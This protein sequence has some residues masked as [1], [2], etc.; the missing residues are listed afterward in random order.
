MQDAETLRATRREAILTSPDS[1]LT[2]LGDVDTKKLGY[3]IDEIQ[4]STWVVAQQNGKVVGMAACK[5]PDQGEDEESHQDSRYIESVWIDPDLR[6]Q[7]LGER[8]IG[9]LMAVEFLKNLNVRQF[10]LWVF[11]TNLSAISLYK[12]LGFVRTPGE[13]EGVRTEIKYRLDVNPE[14]HAAIRQ[15]V[16]EVGV[17]ADKENY[18]VTYR[19]LGEGD[20]A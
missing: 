13:H 17:V 15:T 14:I 1:F 18:G 5:P 12:R 6:G 4:S 11:E 7:R 9:Y 16:G 3:W 19:V 10:L 2:T 20:S 8:L